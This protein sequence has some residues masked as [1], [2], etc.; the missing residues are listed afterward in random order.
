MK[1]DYTT[2][3]HCLTY[4]VPFLKGW[5]NVLFE[6]GSERVIWHSPFSL[7][8]LSLPALSEWN[9]SWLCPL[10]DLVDFLSLSRSLGRFPS[11][12]ACFLSSVGGGAVFSSFQWGSDCSSSFQIS[13][14]RPFLRRK[15]KLADDLFTYTR[16]MF[17]PFKQVQK[18]HS[19]NLLKRNVRS[20]DNW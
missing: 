2:N 9:L 4:T 11:G 13:P 7:L 18:V 20:S 1:D 6:L 8:S 12:L 16:W 14:V 5:K 3:S 10:S 15:T 19:P 17:I